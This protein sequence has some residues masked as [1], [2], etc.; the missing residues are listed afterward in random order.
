[1]HDRQLITVGGGTGAARV[2]AFAADISGQG[3]RPDFSYA[4]WLLGPEDG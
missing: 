3:S 2:P 1:M 4:F